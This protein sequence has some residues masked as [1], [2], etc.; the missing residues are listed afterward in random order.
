MSSSTFFVH[1]KS[2]WSSVCVTFAV[3][4]NS[5]QPHFKHSKSLWLLATM[6]DS[7]ALEY[8]A[9]TCG[10]IW[11]RR[12]DI[13]LA[14]NPVVDLEVLLRVSPATWLTWRDTSSVTGCLAEYWY[15]NLQGCCLNR[16]PGS[17]ILSHQ[18]CLQLGIYIL[19]DFRVQCP[20]SFPVQRIVSSETLVIGCRLY[21]R[22]SITLGEVIVSGCGKLSK[23]LMYKPLLLLLPNT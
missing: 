11:P 18:N 6:L 3:H 17:R 2:S 4:L 15:Q 9:R 5:E 19:R 7:V 13:D 14:H 23:G 20:L 8:I 12:Q 22:R 10:P 16:K 21:Q 1:S